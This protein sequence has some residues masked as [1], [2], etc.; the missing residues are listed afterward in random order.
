M[1]QQQ[2]LAAPP[3]SSPSSKPAS[4][5]RFA[6]MGLAVGLVAVVSIGLMAWSRHGWST[7][8]SGGYT[9]QQQ[10]THIQVQMLE[11]QAQ[12]DDAAR[13]HSLKPLQQAVAAS[14][15]LARDGADDA[16]LSGG[17]HATVLIDQL[18]LLNQQLGVAHETLRLAQRPGV[19][20]KAVVQA[21]LN[22]VLAPSRQ[23]LARV[24][25]HLPEA[26][27]EAAER[28]RRLDQINMALVGLMGVGVVWLLALGHRQRRQ[29]LRALESREAELRAFA[30]ALP[31]LAFLLD[32]NGHYL[33]VFGNNSP[34]LG[35]PREQVVGRPLSD[36]FP[37]ETTQV[38]L[39]V[40]RRALDSRQTQ[41]L[42]Y[43]I[44]V[45]GGT[46]HFDSRCSPVG[47]TDRAVWMVWDVTARRRAEQRLVHMTR[48]YDF[49]SHVNQAIVHSQTEGQLLQ[50]VCETA[51]RHG[52]FKKAWVGMLDLDGRALECQAQAGEVL[53]DTA[54]L[55]MALPAERDDATPMEKAL[56]DGQSFHCA[57]LTQLGDSPPEWA[58]T[59]L[60]ERLNGCAILP[61][62]RQQ[63]LVGYLFLLDRQLNPQ[64]QDEKALLD[65]VAHDLSFAL[66]NLHREVMRE[67]AEERIRLHAAALESSRDGMLVLN[68]ERRLVSINSAFTDITGYTEEDVLGQ[69]AEFLFPEN[70]NDVIDQV[71]DTLRSEGSWEGESWCQRKNGELFSTKMS[72]SAVRNTRGMPT[73]FVAVLTDITQLK[74]S[75][76]R[77]ARMAHYDPLTELP[78]RAMIHERL[79]HAIN[80]ARRHQTLV[81]VV[82]V[83][84]DNFKT[85]NDSLGH[86]AGDTL[87]KL[88][89]HRLRQ[90][91]RQEDTLGRLGGD[92]FILILEHLRH[93][94]QAAHVAQAVI[95]TLSD[96]FVLGDHGQEVYVRASIG[97]SLFPNDSEDTGELVRNADAAMYQAKRVGRNTFKFYTESLTSQATN[98]LSM[99][100]RLR[101]AVEHREFVLHYQPMVRLSDRRV[102]SVEA[103]VRLRV[104]DTTDECLPSIGPDEFIPVMED[105]G[106]IMALGEWVMHEAC[107]QGRAWIDA[108]LDFGRLAVNVSAS[109]IRRGGVLERVSRI[110]RQTGFPA[111]RLELEITE[112]GLM[113]HGDSAEQFLQQLH[114]LGVSLSIDDFG[115]GYS[116][117]AY[118]KRFPVH[119]LKIDRGFVQDLPDNDNDA[120]LVSTMISLAHNLKMRVVAEGVEMPDQEAFLGAR[121]CDMAQGYLF[122]RPVPAAQIE[123]ILP[124]S[125]R[126]SKEVASA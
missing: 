50:R 72:I 58:R 63:S 1:S 20:D 69:T 67:Q 52:H 107:R 96:P 70:P 93:P 101:R 10:M 82:F 112:S 28:Q 4:R 75:E 90:R 79:E 15:H 102:V 34:L 99:E 39:G 22:T 123:K 13:P 11:L 3:S 120:Q 104:P 114:Q 27:A 26:L 54:L 89:S 74:Q 68:R 42:S 97:I 83:D 53:A 14:D 65:D 38:F 47:D 56:I 31:D 94:Q 9:L 33:E 125:E 98:R 77:L 106:M 46:R 55:N 126:A 62:R 48:L 57:D 30:N 66:S 85:V 25:Q 103:L 49:L 118:L 61:L 17:P 110:L 121:G 91:V 32:R 78:N 23:T 19:T 24:Q 5:G 8:Q 2:A 76:A 109:E 113:E 84:L 108:G 80:L 115:T 36:F 40:L 116:S 51:I 37:P 12:G 87:L 60:A 124:R 29:T 6:P 41:S 105:T 35:R 88:V 81:G 7:L 59:A 86:A 117:L 64:D 43:P 44:R 122:S 92:E 73:H 100:T 45:M 21:R 18:R 119:Q 111:D 95:E 16:W 71:A